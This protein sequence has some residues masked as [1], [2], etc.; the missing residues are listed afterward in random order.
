[1]KFD[2][3]TIIVLAIAAACLLAWFIFY[4]G[5]VKKQARENARIAQQTQTA[6][7]VP[8][9]DSELPAV[10]AGN[11]SSDSG[12]S[13]SGKELPAAVQQSTLPSQIPDLAEKLA[14]AKILTLSNDLMTVQINSGSGVIESIQLNSFLTA[15]KTHPIQIGIHG[16]RKTFQTN[17]FTQSP[18][19]SFECVKHEAAEII[20]KRTYADGLTVFQTYRIH[21]N[22]YQIECSY[23]LVN[24]SQNLITI[25][26]FEV[27]SCGVPPMH[28]LA[29]DKIYTER[30]NLDYC[31]SRDK[32]VY[33]F[34]PDAK[35]SK[36]LN[37]LTDSPVDWVGSSNKFSA[38]LLFASASEPFNAGIDL[39]RV[40][41]PTATDPEKKYVVPAIAGIYK[42]L[43]I[44]PNGSKTLAFQYYC[45]P[46]EISRISKLHEEAMKVMHISVFSWFEFIARPMLRFLIWL[47]GLCGSYG[48]AIILL[49]IIVRVIFW[50]I[51]QKANNSM[52]KMQKIQPLIKDLR[53]KYKN[54]P[55]ELNSRMMQLYKDYKVNPLG[56]C[57]P[58]LLQIPVFLALYSALDSSVELRHVSFLWAT[59][60]TK[61]DLIGPTVNLPLIGQFG[62]HPLV[63]IMTVLMI[64][65]QKLTPTGAD[66]MQQKMMMAM[67]VIMLV[68]FYNLPSGLTLYWTVSQIFSIVQLKYG[69]YLAKK[70][71][72]AADSSRSNK[73]KT[74]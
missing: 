71:E 26:E 68:L 14:S 24:H 47:K 70:E 62:L 52:R 53:E 55:Q 41:Y 36:F 40:Y 18:L 67:P 59:D 46:K 61:A 5:Y 72:D 29:G 1:M 49:T 19:L 65:Q 39:Q 32:S 20:L 3:E 7:P 28:D 10:S 45:G 13:V 38:S 23:Q 27:W 63:I 73:K 34:S 15:D 56:G 11:S 16:I 33:S 6:V 74:A 12:N 25:P 48:I 2:K 54:N 30:H 35:E 43:Q 31:L 64:L 58:I 21:E 57:L 8:P 37:A 50:P 60:L 42:N 69:Q 9:S 4:P 22:S 66:P 44:Q 51:T 17:D